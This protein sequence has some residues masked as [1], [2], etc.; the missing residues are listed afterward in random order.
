MKKAFF[1]IF[2]GI[3]LKQIKIFF[4]KGESPTLS[5]YEQSLILMCFDFCC[6]FFSRYTYWYCEF[7]T[8]VGLKICVITA[9][10]KKYQSLIKKVRIR[11]DKTS[12]V[13]KI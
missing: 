8:T 12:L 4:L 2:E 7:C 13:S 11:H 9:W 10:T 1:I 6:Y 3:S 5:Y